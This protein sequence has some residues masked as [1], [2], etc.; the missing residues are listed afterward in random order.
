MYWKKRNPIGLSI[1]K[2][3]KETK[4]KYPIYFS[5]S[6]PWVDCEAE[7]SILKKHCVKRE[8]ER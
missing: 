6:Q 8:R 4:V 1:S 3:V 5:T 2:V 7:N